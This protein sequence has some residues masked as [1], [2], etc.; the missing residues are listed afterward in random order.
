MSTITEQEQ[1]EWVRKN[2]DADIDDLVHYHLVVSTAVVTTPTIVP[3]AG[4]MIK[5]TA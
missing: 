3:L 4:E 2:A 5:A 1:R